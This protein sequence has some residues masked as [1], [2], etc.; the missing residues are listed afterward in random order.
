MAIKKTKTA[1][2][3]EADAEEL[4][5][6]VDADAGSDGSD[7]ADGD[8]GEGADAGTSTDID[9]IELF[10]DEEER[11][12]AQNAMA[13]RA[14]LDRKTR[15]GAKDEVADDDEADDADDDKPVTRKE[16][17][18]MEERATANAEKR[19]SKQQ[20]YQIALRLASGNEAA[21]KATV[22][23]YE[24]RVVPTGDLEADVKFAFGGLHHGK[25]TATNA[26][27]ARALKA[28]GGVGRAPVS[29]QQDGDASTAP[30]L[31]PDMAASLKISGFV[32]GKDKLWRKT[33]P[34]GNSLTK[35]IKTGKTTLVKKQRR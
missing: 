11:K 6:G 7:D 10:K 28:S 29:G 32:Y 30:K 22:L 27:L 1:A 5:T 18:A 14:Y 9:Y 2:V 4:E 13:G 21:A 35:D 8:D 19:I 17:A 23:F 33:L 26:E 3:E 20:A 16:L 25:L 31:A 12:K 15:K 24:N 34:N